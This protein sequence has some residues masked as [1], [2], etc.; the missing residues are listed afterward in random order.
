MKFTY[1]IWLIHPL[2]FFFVPCSLSLLGVQQ[3]LGQVR[4]AWT[5]DQ[6]HSP[7]PREVR[8]S[9]AAACARRGDL[10]CQKGLRPR[11]GGKR[12]LFGPIFGNRDPRL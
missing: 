7:E 6:I 2:L 8:D 12:S 9:D 11:G 3:D 1:G 10:R 5:E 4:D